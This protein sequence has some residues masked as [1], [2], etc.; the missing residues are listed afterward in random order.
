[1]L[2]QR[3]PQLNRNGELVHLL[4]IDG[5]PREVLVQILDT[6]GTFLSVNDREVKK[7]RRASC[8][9]RVWNCV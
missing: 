9:E 4:S 3:N 7:I 6:A 8:R 2:L 1:M 5:L